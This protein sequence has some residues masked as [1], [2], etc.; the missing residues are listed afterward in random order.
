M[1]YANLDR[2][3]REAEL[4]SGSALPIPVVARWMSVTPPAIRSMLRRG[5]LQ[6]VSIGTLTLVS[7]I[8]LRDWQAAFEA[9]VK[10]TRKVLLKA[11][12]KSKP[13]SYG[14]L[15]NKLGRDYT[16]PADRRR[17]GRLLD[18]VSAQSYLEHQALLS[19]W[20]ISKATG[21]PKYGVWELAEEH[22]IR[23][24]GEDRE[25]FVARIRAEMTFDQ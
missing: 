13:I 23:V 12:R 14:D 11:A 16:H 21:M 17:L 6:P 20:A 2:Y 25:T 3:L 19:A 1:H 9:E 5:V 10:K 15:L 24:K 22:G 7:A 8:S 18:M 4:S